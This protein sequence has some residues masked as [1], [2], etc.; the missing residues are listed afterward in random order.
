MKK[1][2]TPAAPK[3]IHYLSSTHWDREWYQPFQGFRF[4]LVQMVDDLLGILERDPDY[5]V[6]HFDGQ[7]VVAEDY[8]DIRPENRGRLEEL[9][10]AGR[11]LFGPWYVMPDEFLVSGEALIRNLQF[12][13]RVARALGGKPW[14]FGYVCDIFGH[15]AQFPQILAGFGIRAASLGRGTNEHTTP[16]FF[17]WRSPDGSEVLTWK[18]PDPMGYGDFTLGVLK[19]WSYNYDARQLDGKELRRVKEALPGYVAKEQARTSVP[20]VVITDGVDHEP[21]HPYIPQLLKELRLRFPKTEV[22]MENLEALADDLEPYRSR[23]P[24]KE[25]ELIEPGKAQSMFIYLIPNT[26]SSRY[27]L[28]KWNDRCQALL[29]LTV[30]PLHAACLARGGRDEQPYLRKAWQYLLKNHPHDSICGCSIDSVHRDMEYRFR[31]CETLATTVLEENST[32]DPGLEFTG[33][34]TQEMKVRLYNPLPFHR[35][36]AFPLTLDF[37][38]SW[39]GRYAEAFGYE[40]LNAFRIFAGKREVPYGITR[41][42]RGVHKRVYNQKGVSVDRFEIEAEL[43]LA[44]M[45]WTEVTVKSADMPTRHRKSQLAGARSA[46]NSL[47]ALQI[48]DNGTIDLVDKISGLKRCGLMDYSSV[49]EIGDGWFHTPTVN[50]GRSWANSSASVRLITDTPACTGFSIRRELRVPAEVVPDGKSYMSSV[51]E[52]TVGLEARVFLREGWPG[53]QV[54]LVVDNTA[55]D[56]KLS[57]SIPTGLPGG[58]YFASQAFCMLERECGFSTATDDWKEAEWTERNFAGITGKRDAEGRGLAF[59]SPFGLH[60]VAARAD[61]AGTLDITLLRCS[62]RTVHTNGEPDGQLQGRQDF[63]FALL[64]LSPEDDEAGLWRRQQEMQAP[65]LVQCAPADFSPSPVQA[66][67]TFLELRGD[68]LVFSSCKRAEED[69]GLVALRVFNPSA[70]PV[71][72]EARFGIGVAEA[73][74]ADLDE[75]PGEKVKAGKSGFQISLGPWK[76]QTYLVRLRSPVRG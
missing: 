58:K 4:R 65:P 40:Q 28:K 50:A 73:R 5:K 7:G 26:V 27:L 44:P 49:S 41:M 69:A 72:G 9:T 24:V 30:E 8:L 64:C 18:S 20:I 1:P 56:H 34:D 21:A 33:T 57:L 71:T 10:R 25:G 62:R 11:V 31:Q 32:S 76:M 35:R 2:K 39:K 67:E 47:V 66:G 70:Q 3:K 60:E 63:R 6:F 45:G 17:R 74:L 43:E 12:G 15:A 14:R 37:P 22:T 75:T 46:E 55:K 23:L 19:N 29:E 68:G 59:I 38:G 36:G 51:Q 16:A 42:Q 52:V 61:A 13:N 53:I 54:E 48:L